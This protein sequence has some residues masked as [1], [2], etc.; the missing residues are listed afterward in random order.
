MKRLWRGLQAAFILGLGLL[1]LASLTQAQPANMQAPVPTGWTVQEVAVLR[2]VPLATRLEQV[3]SG[4]AGVFETLTKEMVDSNEWNSSIWLRFHLVVNHEKPL[5]LRE[6]LPLLL[7]LNKPYIDDIRLF[8]PEISASGPRI[9]NWQV[10][11]AGDTVAHARW[12][13]HMN[14]LLPRFAM[15]SASEVR[16]AGPQ[17]MQVY[18]QVSSMVP[19]RVFVQFV[20]Q[21]QA[22]RQDTLMPVLYGLCL[23]AIAMALLGALLSW[24]LQ[25]DALY[26]WYAAYALMAML[27]IVSHSG[28]GHMLLWPVGGLWPGTAAPFFIV[29][30]CIM[31]LY[32][33]RLI[34]LR[35]RSEVNMG[36][37]CKTMLWAGLI[38]N[39]CFVFVPELW[40]LLYFSFLVFFGITIV[41]CTRWCIQ[42]A[43][44]GQMIGE[45]WLI[46][47]VPLYGVSIWTILDNMG[48]V[49]AGSWSHALGIIATAVDVAAVGLVLQWFARKRH[50]AQERERALATRDPLTGFATA[51]VFKS[52]LQRGWKYSQARGKDVAV[53]YV[54]LMATGDNPLRAELM[55]AR[56]VRVLR[57]ATRTHDIVGRLEKNLL[58]VILPHISLGDDLA[59]RLARIIAQGLMPDPSDPNAIVL[60][61]RIA[62]TSFQHFQSDIKTLDAELRALLA[63]PSGWGS[64]PIRYIDHL[65][66][67][68]QAVMDSTALDD[69]WSKAFAAEQK[70]DRM[71]PK[72]PAAR[73]I[74]TA[75]SPLK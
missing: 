45:V 58:A 3:L 35:T 59:Q 53:A 66:K 32:F 61:F 69:I 54:Q 27:A 71:T 41:F 13:A 74:T 33:C 29:L 38:L 2:D 67:Q 7:S 40:Q 11:R 1:G 46:G 21:A 31:A 62:A 5:P 14:G 73:R 43:R 20:T 12:T 15:P 48:L 65:A 49:S 25:R 63:K 51:E 47:S 8:T 72:K 22:E 36:W 56:S 26:G 30:A 16:A 19:K 50:A 64:K 28:L 6:R 4:Q 39:F 37:V 23:G 24:R 34:L 17:G 75:P 18:L 68:Q 55:L 70:D 9:E 42:S 10:Q 52:R 60:Q 44:R 57:A